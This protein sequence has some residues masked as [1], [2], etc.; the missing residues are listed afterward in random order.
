MKK[1][2]RTNHHHRLSRSRTQGV[3]FNGNIEGIS[4]VN[5]VDYKKHQAFHCLFESTHP[6][7]IA[8]ELND[9][10]CD[11]HYIILAISKKDA[12]RIRKILTQLT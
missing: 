10:W 2:R 8:K 1:I 9:K 4:N 12:K 5:L 7:D 11:P 3:P 6:V